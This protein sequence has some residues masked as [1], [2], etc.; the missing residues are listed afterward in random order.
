MSGAGRKSSYRKG[1]AQQY[2]DAH[3]LPD[4]NARVVRI[5]ASRGSNLFDI[6]LQT[7][8]PALAMLPTKF[9]KL[10]WV[11]RGDYVLVSSASADATTLEGDAKVRYL[12]VHILSKEQI[13]HIQSEGLWYG[14]KITLCQ[15]YPHE[16]ISC[17]R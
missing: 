13:R 4:E 2:T 6:E 14:A 7:G 12:I 5:T 9:R 1:V 3:P 17:I 15:T 8:E 11:K 16:D 10:I